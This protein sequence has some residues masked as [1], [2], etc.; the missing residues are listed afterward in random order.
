MKIPLP[1]KALRALVKKG[2]RAVPGRPV[3]PGKCG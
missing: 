1:I 2:A 3:V